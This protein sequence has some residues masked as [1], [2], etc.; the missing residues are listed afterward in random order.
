MYL[1][2]NELI[3]QMVVLVVA[4]NLDDLGVGFSLGIKGKIPWRVIWT[5]SI[6]SGITMAIGLIVGDEL[7]DFIPEN[8]A[9]YLA[10]FVF[11]CIGLWLIWQ[12]FKS[13]DEETN[14]ASSNLGWKAAFVLG[15]AL[16]ID[17]FAAGFSGG[18]TDFPILL[19]SFLAW[20]TS[21]V[22]I[23]LGSIFG[24]ALSVK[25]IRDYAEYF[26]G[27]CFLFLA[28]VILYF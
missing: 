19:T 26:S 24:S 4:S 15:I 9:L 10:A 8:M 12:G 5:V 3:W 21:F 1:G 18:L 14:I 11:A 25:F 27:G 7:A 6:L 16:G 2:G 22:F 23:W 28:V 13:K 20:I 17:S